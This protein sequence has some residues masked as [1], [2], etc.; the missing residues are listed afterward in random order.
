MDKTW[1]ETEMDTDRDGIDSET[2][3]DRHKGTSKTQDTD[4][5][6]D[7]DHYKEGTGN[8]SWVAN[9]MNLK[10]MAKSG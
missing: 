8:T 1:I 10:L 7:F 5:D 4:T 9:Q 3:R 6:G 2:Q